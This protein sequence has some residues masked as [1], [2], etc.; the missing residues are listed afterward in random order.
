M[1]RHY[2]T[3]NTWLT[4][5]C[6]VTMRVMLNVGKTISHKLQY[7]RLCWVSTLF[8]MTCCVFS[9]CKKNILHGSDPYTTCCKWST[10][11]DAR[12]LHN[13]MKCSMLR[14]AFFR[15]RNKRCL[16]EKSST[17]SK[18]TMGKNKLDL[19]SPRISGRILQYTFLV[20]H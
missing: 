7:M 14:S 8:D 6:E 13:A 3:C 4:N 5:T 16:Y 15:R 1:L 9:K 2:S 18:K 10:F 19:S 12:T 17:L 11:L 20:W